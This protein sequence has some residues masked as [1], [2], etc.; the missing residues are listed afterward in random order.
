MTH[1]DALG[2]LASGLVL[3]AFVMKD[4]VELRIVAIGSNL[5]FLAHGL[6]LDLPPRVASPLGAAA[7]ERLASDASDADRCTK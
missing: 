5:V 1:C 6:Y 2:Y 4:M 3:A 7:A